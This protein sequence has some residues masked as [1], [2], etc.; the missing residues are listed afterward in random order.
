MIDCTVTTTSIH[1]KH[2]MFHADRDGMLCS[3]V[4]FL[5]CSEP[6]P[7]W[8]TPTPDAAGSTCCGHSGTCRS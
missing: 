2:D 6:S 3:F 8:S 5:P 7:L 1:T 4:P